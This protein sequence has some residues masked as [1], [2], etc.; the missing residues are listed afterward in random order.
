MG[1]AEIQPLHPGGVRIPVVERSACP[2]A[3]MAFDNTPHEKLNQLVPPAEFSAAI[4]EINEAIRP[5]EAHVVF[6]ALTVVWHLTVLALTIAGLVMIASSG[7]W[8]PLLIASSVMS[9][10]G[11]AV[12]LYVRTLFHKHRFGRVRAAVAAQHN[13]LID[14]GVTVKLYPEHDPDFLLEGAFLDIEPV[15]PATLPVDGHSYPAA[16]AVV[17]TASVPEAYI[18]APYPDGVGPWASS[19]TALMHAPLPPPY[20]PTDDHTRPAYLAPPAYAPS[21]EPPGFGEHE[22]DIAVVTVPGEADKAGPV[23]ESEDVMKSLV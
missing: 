1:L 6:E 15:T 4:D 16:S 11:F 2:V 20:Q 7:A 21:E 3:E 19:G 12:R 8:V 23:G 17:D 13:R 18:Y 14:R 10:A 5:T 22:V 9:C